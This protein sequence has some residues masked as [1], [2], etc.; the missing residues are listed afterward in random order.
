MT[1]WADHYRRPVIMF[2]AQDQASLN[3]QPSMSEMYLISNLADCWVCSSMKDQKKTLLILSNI[4]SL[5]FALASA[6]KAHTIFIF[7]MVH[8]LFSGL[9]LTIVDASMIGA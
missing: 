5:A 2:H 7:T 6:L 9:I 1:S 4:L 8:I 3:R